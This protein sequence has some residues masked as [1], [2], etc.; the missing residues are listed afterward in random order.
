MLCKKL[1]FTYMKETLVKIFFFNFSLTKFKY[2]ISFTYIS[3]LY[4]RS[5]T[6]VPFSVQQAQMKKKISSKV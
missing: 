1:K 6:K 4:H 3:K 5:T 2:Q